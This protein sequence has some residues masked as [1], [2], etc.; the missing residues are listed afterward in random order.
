MR[1]FGF[2]FFT[3]E[4]PK[5]PAAHDDYWYNSVSGT[6]AG[7][8]ITPETAMQNTV[9]LAC[10]RV[11][12]ESIAALPLHIYKRETG[13]GKVKATN[14]ELYKLLHVRPNEWQTHFRFFEMMT[15]HALLRGNGYAQKLKN[16]RGKLLGLVP[17]NPGRMEP[18]YVRAEDDSVEKV[19][20]YT[21]EKGQRV[22]FPAEEI[23]HIQGI[24][25]D[26]LKGIS[27]IEQ[28]R[29]AIGLALAAE[30]HGTEF[31]ENDATPGGILSTEQVLSDE[32]VA[33]LKKQWVEKHGQGKR[34]GVAVLEQG[35][36]WKT[37]GATNKD[38]QFLELRRMQVEEVARLFRV[39]LHMVGDLTRS[40]NNNIEH[41]SIE[42]VVHCLVPWLRRWEE[43]IN[44]SLFSEDEWGTYFCEFLVDGLLRGDTQSRYNAY[45]VARNNG[46]MN[47]DEIRAFENMNPL[48]EGKGQEYLRPLNMVP[49]GD[50]DPKLKEPQQPKEDKK[51]DPDPKEEDEDRS[52]AGLERAQYAFLRSA[53]DAIDRVVRREAAELRDIAKSSRKAAELKKPENRV[54]M[55]EN[56]RKLA[57]DA[58]KT[59]VLAWIEAVIVAEGRGKKLLGK[60]SNTAEMAANLAEKWGESYSERLQ[61]TLRTAANSG[62]LGALA[63]SI[64]RTL[65]RE[66]AELWIPKI[67]AEVESE[68]QLYNGQNIINQIHIDVKPEVRAPDVTVSVAPQKPVLVER[69]TFFVNDDQGNRIGAKTKERIVE[70]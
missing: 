44:Q 46:W 4:D 14:H 13:G 5:P 52:L 42:F 66:Q 27:V 7:M 1:L 3:R 70:N 41:Q 25:S 32:A 61:E 69:D 55:A 54:K 58:V 62:D 56:Y 65:A 68:L 10:V 43:E 11:I 40:T 36:D 15:G 50:E 34:H 20:L 12:A 45:A 57:S 29:R 18:R 60:L 59:P 19:Y 39:P 9:V 30:E 26:G 47:V 63:E 21:T 48:P 22:I 37:M 53:E 64:I 28:A 38:S 24:S 33:R 6:V 16:N 31:F 35:L 51:P 8:R 17:L 67:R 2:S 23:L 49:V